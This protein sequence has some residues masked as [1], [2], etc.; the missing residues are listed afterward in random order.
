[1]SQDKQFFTT[2]FVIMAGLAVLAIILVITAT[3]LTSD[4][5]E[6]KPEAVVIENI[7]PVGQVYV[8]GESE[9]E[10][11]A[12]MA[13]DAGAAAGPKSG[14]E[15]YN[16]NCMACHATG[17]AGA[18]KL[19]DAAAWAPRIA[20]GKEKLLANATNGLNAMPP[21]GLCMACSEAELQAAIDYM[22][23]KSQ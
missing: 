14:E 3:S 9:P 1:M 23:S 13:A 17:A 20:Q 11:P 21:K 7:K 19:G 2:F 22:V 10:Q 8:A 12:A 16:S 6:Y 5:S 4:V 18:P 15:V